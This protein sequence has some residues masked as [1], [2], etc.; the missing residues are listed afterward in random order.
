MT[1]EVLI[2]S[3]TVEAV[4]MEFDAPQGT[5]QRIEVK[6]NTSDEKSNPDIRVSLS[7]EEAKGLAEAI[8]ET[9]KE[10]S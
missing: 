8:L 3:V 9:I 7:H 1:K 2:E 5:V 4:E 10:Q 6:L